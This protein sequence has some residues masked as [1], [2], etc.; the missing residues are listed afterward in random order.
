[1]GA[2]PMNP[3]TAPFSS[4]RNGKLD[5]DLEVNIVPLAANYGMMKLYMFRI[6]F[7]RREVPISPQG[8]SYKA[9]I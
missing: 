3:A 4:V 1:M 8:I 7:S 5:R 2:V 6:F 9:V